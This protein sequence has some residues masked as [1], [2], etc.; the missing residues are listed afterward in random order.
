VREPRPEETMR[1]RLVLSTL[2]LLG[3]C[4]TATAQDNY[5]SRPVEVIVPYAPGGGSDIMVRNMV[6][7][8]EQHKLVPVPIAVVN[9]AGGGGAIARTQFSQAQPDGYTLGVMDPNPV[10]Q[11]LLGEAPQ[12]YRTDFTYIAKL[13]DD[14]NFLIVKT[15]SS[16]KT[17][18]D[19]VAEI[20]KR[21]PKRFSIAGT[22]TGSQ[23]H[24][25]SIDF[26][27]AIGQQTNYLVTKSGGEVLTTL[28]GGHVDAAWA[29]PSE[30]IEQYKAG[31]VRILAVGDT[32]RL[33]D[34]PDVP[35]FK[36]AGVDM[37]SYN[38]RGIGGPPRLPKPVVDYWT[39]VLGKMRETPDWK[40][41][42][43]ARVYQEDG[44]LVGEQLMSYVHKEHDQ[45]KGMFEKLGMLKK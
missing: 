3:G 37:V 8:I 36:E 2:V 44:W 13:V 4:V 29:N 6:K 23:D 40:Q 31:Q 22:A 5:P 26:D 12:N 45:F 43:L 25:A 19:A 10:L 30:C 15:D 27:A 35:T 34:F 18:A 28:L 16:V 32:K 20:K 17:L 9:K 42:Y 7:V 21:G 1:M 41:G 11:Q 39:D 14:V 33:A 38:W 24:V